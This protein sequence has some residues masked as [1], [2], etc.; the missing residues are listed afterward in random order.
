MS[1]VDIIWQGNT[2]CVA[3]SYDHLVH[4]WICFLRDGQLLV[5]SGIGPQRRGGRATARRDRALRAA[6][7]MRGQ[8]EGSV[9][10]KAELPIPCLRGWRNLAV[11]G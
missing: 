7:Q 5:D 2:V 3:A 11:F 8:R 10:A 6:H 1:Y 4:F 9:D